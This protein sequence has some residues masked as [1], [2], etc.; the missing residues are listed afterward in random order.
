MPSSDDCNGNMDKIPRKR[1][2]PAE[3]VVRMIKLGLIGNLFDFDLSS[4][5]PGRDD[6]KKVR[7]KNKSFGKEKQKWRRKF[8][9]SRMEAHVRRNSA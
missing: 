6:K 2:G 4:N 7:N 9:P 3:G 8:L 5:N 1:T